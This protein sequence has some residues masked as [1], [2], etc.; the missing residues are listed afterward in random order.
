MRFAHLTTLVMDIKEAIWRGALVAL[1]RDPPQQG[2][3][4][5]T[6]SWY[7]IRLW[8]EIVGNSSLK[9]H[10]AWPSLLRHPGQWSEYKKR[11]I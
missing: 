3:A 1:F 6:E 2:P 7:S 9:P 10:A 4:E 11:M 8:A 5:F